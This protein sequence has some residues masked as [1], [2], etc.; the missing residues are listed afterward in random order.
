MK[1]EHIS[2]IIDGRQDGAIIGEYLFSFNHKGECTVYK[3]EDVLR[4]NPEPF[5]EFSLDKTLIPHSNSVTFG[6]EFYSE[7]D[8]FP[9]L[10]TNIYNNYSGEQDKMVGT[11]LV[12]RIVRNKNVFTSE[13]VQIIKIGFSEDALWGSDNGDI[14]PYGNCVID[15]ENNLYYAYT[16]RD[17]D[18]KTRYFAFDLPD[19]SSGDI[20]EKYNVKKVLLDKSEI[21]FYFDC[22]YHHFI[23]GGTLSDGKIYSLEGFTGNA[24]NPPAMRIIDTKAK[25]EIK[26][27]NFGDYG[28][29]IEP[30][31]IDF[32]KNECIYGDHN[33]NIYKINLQ[34]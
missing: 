10:Y 34:E 30:E 5:S 8:E 4:G 17:G 14:R 18:Y 7:D 9:C 26:S 28:L 6:K 33:G 22:P 16:M 24:E 31:M 2:C 11:T 32:Y 20:D 1:F 15:K 21:K 3:M 27:I 23:Q 19:V 12:Y 25:K 13:L 29:N